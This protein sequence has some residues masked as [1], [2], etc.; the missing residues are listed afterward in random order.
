MANR[1]PH[2]LKWSL[3]EAPKAVPFGIPHS[4]LPKYFTNSRERFTW[5]LSNRDWKNQWWA[6]VPLKNYKTHLKTSKEFGFQWREN[7]LCS[8]RYFWR[9]CMNW[10]KPDG[11]LREVHY[12]QQLAAYELKASSLPESHIEPTMKQ[13]HLRYV[14][15]KR[16]YKSFCYC[17]E[18]L[19]ELFVHQCI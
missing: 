14:R 4:R 3:K 9:A 2:G 15:K 8:Q 10:T 11:Q 6:T 13:L 19:L 12:N 1:V 5:F 7:M 16:Y 18:T 17:N